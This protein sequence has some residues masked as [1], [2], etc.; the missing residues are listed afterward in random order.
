MILIYRHLLGT[1]VPPFF[2]GLSVTT[3]V[4]MIDVLSKYIDLFLEKG[5]HV[6]LATEVLF[7]SLGHTFALS[8]P[9]AVLVGTLMSI[10]SLAAD[11]EITAL[12]ANGVSL[13]QTTMPLLGM[14]TLLCALMIFYNHYVLP[15][16]NHRLTNLLIEI[17]QLR[18]TLRVEPN[19]FVRIDDRYT[20][21]VREKN[22]RTGELRGVKL[23]QARGR[24]DRFPDVI[25][26]R[27][28]VLRTVAPG[29]IELELRS[30]EMHSMPDT[31]NTA[32]YQRTAFSRQTF[33]IDLGPEGSARSREQRGQRE[34]NLSHLAH[35]RREELGQ[36]E[37]A[38]REARTVLQ[39]ALLALGSLR[40]PAPVDPAAGAGP[41]ASAPF[42]AYRDLVAATTRDASALALKAQLVDA[43]RLKA[44]QYAVEYHKKFAIPVA[45]IVFVLLGVPLGVSTGR[46]GRGVSTGISL[47]AFLVYYLFLTGGE[48]LADRGRLSPWLSMWMANFVLGGLG[49]ALLIRSVREV[50]VLR[51]SRPA[52]VRRM[53]TH[54]LR[55]GA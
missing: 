17:H 34:M 16:S 21:F 4:L 50:H 37:D 31:R 26:A 38:Q 29:R 27:T 8:I 20:I 12:R 51:L 49:V 24:G 42:A 53:W 47:A 23:Y 46:G 30:G 19:M 13:Y 10:G 6:G 14:G 25:V 39:R 3:F 45:C 5:I 48:K 41:G 43:H 52:W 11:H 9:M 22:D 33:N 36:M 40:S 32:T 18:P 55:Q 2:F 28:G 44:S 7:L 35:G 15:E 54:W 1:F